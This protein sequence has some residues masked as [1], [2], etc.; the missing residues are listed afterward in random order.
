MLTGGGP[1][2]AAARPEVRP[3][4]S[5]PGAA[6]PTPSRQPS[7]RPLVVVGA[8]GGAGVSTLAWLL[9]PAVDLGRAR[10]WRRL[11]NPGRCPVAL[12]CGCTV[13]ATGQ[14]V[15][16]VAAAARAGVGLDVLVV[17]G[18]G[19]PVPGAARARLRL[20]A[21]RVGRVVRVPYVPG[22][23]YVER[24]DPAGLPRAV[25]LA[26]AAVRAAV[27]EPSRR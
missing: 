7:A 21:G 17:V 13:P 6:V 3:P 12:V 26:V 1:G 2:A 8:H 27:D 9:A 16:E 20:L 11:V 10:D 22:W 4:G 25:V 14:A 24:P 23:R 18:D 19:W 15:G 5:D